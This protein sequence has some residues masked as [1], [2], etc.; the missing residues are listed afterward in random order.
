M[1]NILKLACVLFCIVGL[2][3]NLMGCNKLNKAT[4]S[5]STMTRDEFKAKLTVGMSKQA[6]IDAV[7]TPD[8]TSDL[9]SKYSFSYRN[10]AVDSITGKVGH[11]T[12]WF[13][14]KGLYTH[15]GF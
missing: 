5:I 1:R 9:G 2:V 10:K 11:A 13:D 12:V 6:V 8:D 3:P 4:N 15:V 14:N 7:G